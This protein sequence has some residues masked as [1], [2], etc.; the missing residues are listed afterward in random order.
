MT[1]MFIHHSLSPKAHGIICLCCGCWWFVIFIS[2]VSTWHSSMPAARRKW[3][4]ES[5][6][7]RPENDVILCFRWNRKPQKTLK[8]AE[9]FPGC[10]TRT[11]TFGYSTESMSHVYNI[12]QYL[13]WHKT[14]NM[15]LETFR[16]SDPIQVA[17]GQKGIAPS[18][19]LLRIS[20][21]LCLARDRQRTG[22]G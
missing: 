4:D 9:H 3:V 1:S 14:H 17:T 12:F 16:W 13:K 2:F 7:S 5:F 22:D 18:W 21:A 15:L 8:N 19:K 20:E 11:W 6:I 10:L